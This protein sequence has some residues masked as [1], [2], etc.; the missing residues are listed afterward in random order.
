[1]KHTVNEYMLYYKSKPK[2]NQCQD[3][4]VLVLGISALPQNHTV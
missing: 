4:N 1:M 3:I 2:T